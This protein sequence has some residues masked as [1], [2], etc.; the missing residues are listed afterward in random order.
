MVPA[1]TLGR[2]WLRWGKQKHGLA[3]AIPSASLGMG[4]SCRLKPTS[5][6]EG[7]GETEWMGQSWAAEGA[8]W[9]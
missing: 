4:N 3:L 7:R 2:G 5:P 8:T 6:G 1:L 9:G